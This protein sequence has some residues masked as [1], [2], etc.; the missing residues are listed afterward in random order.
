[1]LH[2]ALHTGIELT[3]KLEELVASGTETLIYTVVILLRSIANGLPYLLYLEKL[4]AEL[5]PLLA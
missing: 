3:L 2:L 5:V 4:V 1:M